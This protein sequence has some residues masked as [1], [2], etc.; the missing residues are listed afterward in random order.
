MQYQSTIF[1]MSRWRQSRDLPLWVYH[2]EKG[3]HEAKRFHSHNFMEVVLVRGKGSHLLEEFA[4]PVCEQDILLIPPGFVHAY[5]DCEELEILNLAYDPA[6]LLIP[7]LDG[8]QLPF[9]NRLFP[10]ETDTSDPRQAAY[11]ALHP[12]QEIFDKLWDKILHLGEHIHSVEPGQNFLALGSFL[13]IIGELS[14]LG[15]PS[16]S[17]VA[18][19]EKLQ[20]IINFMNN[21]LQKDLDIEMLAHYAAMSERNFHRFFKQMT[22]SSPMQYLISLR[23]RKAAQLL[24]FKSLPLDEIALQ[25]GFCDANYLARCMKQKLNT[26]PKKVQKNRLFPEKT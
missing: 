24:Q 12:P 19:L 14:Q 20:N 15:T 23:L 9:F 10:L 26:T 21:N 6:H 16:V 5:C 22:G 18:D 13:H 11:P 17:G 25:C 4:V 2:V 7:G 8:Y 3:R 1:T